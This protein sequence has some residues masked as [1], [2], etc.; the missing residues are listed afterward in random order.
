MADEF[1]DELFEQLRAERYREASEA[2]SALEKRRL[3]DIFATIGSAETGGLIYFTDDDFP[4]LDKVRSGVEAGDRKAMLELLAI[5]AA[6]LRAFDVLT[7]EVREAL[8]D[9][10]GKM[11]NILE[12]SK[13]F[14]PT[15]SGK[16]SA[17]LTQR[18]SLREFFTAMEVERYRRSDGYSLED[19]IAKVAEDFGITDHLV[20]K[21]W[22]RH[23]KDA[24]LSVDCSNRI[25]QASISLLQAGE[26]SGV[27]LIDALCK[28]AIAPAVGHVVVPSRTK[29]RRK[30]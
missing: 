16:R 26:H 17:E 8:A 14:L 25:S 6:S 19:A 30:L 27:S 3:N 2:Y 5:T 21:R 28:A 1:N 11:Q 15:G 18:H 24:K 13:G 29:H 22:K 23:H 20:Q 7:K 9:G 4:T 12:E 10:M